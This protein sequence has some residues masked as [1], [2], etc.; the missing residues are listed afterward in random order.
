MTIMDA[1]KYIITYCLDEAAMDNDRTAVT[2]V[3][4][5]EDALIPLMAANEYEDETVRS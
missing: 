3:D 2:A 1:W 4:T 5:I